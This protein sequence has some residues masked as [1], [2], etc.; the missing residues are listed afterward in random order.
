MARGGWSS[1][2]EFYDELAE[3]YHL[4]YGSGWQCAIH[5]QGE[6]LDGLIRGRLPA[7]RSVLD[8]SCGIGT[9]AIGLGLR[10]YEVT[11][12]DISE[13]SLVR[14]AQTARELDVVLQTVRADFRDLSALDDDFDVVM[15][16]DNAIP[17]LLDED[18]VDLVLQQMHDKLRPGGLLIA[19]TRDYETALAERRRTFPPID[20]PGPPRQLVVRV[21]EWDEPD[22]LLYTVR[23]LILTQTEMGWGVTERATR[24]RALP[25]RRL[26]EAAERAGLENVEWMPASHA[27]FHQPV[28]VARRPR[29]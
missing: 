19:S 20:V 12:S 11:G 24:Y 7:A 5:R 14:A 28:L 22:G 27:H 25:A 29:H 10:G 18:D 15:S 23:F 4:V 3:D 13:R 9:Q 6:A 17:H 26:A 8:C 16:C 1:V 2:V 21:H